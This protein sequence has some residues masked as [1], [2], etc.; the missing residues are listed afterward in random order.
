MYVSIGEIMFL[1]SKIILISVICS[2]GQAFRRSSPKVLGG[3]V[4]DLS[5]EDVNQLK[6]VHRTLTLALENLRP[7]PGEKNTYQLREQDLHD[8]YGQGRVIWWA[9]QIIGGLLAGG[10]IG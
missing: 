5:E 1:V 3:D 7:V 9:L 4:I 6:Q 10:V 2:A 8:G